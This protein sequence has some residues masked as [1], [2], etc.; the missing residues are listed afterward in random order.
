[1]LVITVGN[2]FFNAVR[3]LFKLVIQDP[4]PFGEIKADPY[5]TYGTELATITIR[6]FI[7]VL[8]RFLIKQYRW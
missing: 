5:R 2:Y 7:L 3:Y 8:T 1:M 6:D 4:D